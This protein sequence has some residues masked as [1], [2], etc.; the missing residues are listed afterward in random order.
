MRFSYIQRYT[1]YTPYISRYTIMG[2][3]SRGSGHGFQMRFGDLSLYRLTVVH[4]SFWEA[5]MILAIEKLVEF[6]SQHHL[7][8]SIPGLCLLSW[9]PASPYNRPFEHFQEYI[10]LSIIV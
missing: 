10:F 1:Q 2:Y 3:L 7:I 8:Q 9:T 5:I 4:T 6:R